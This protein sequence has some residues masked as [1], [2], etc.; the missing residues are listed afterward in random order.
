MSDQ[1]TVQ[2]EV[3]SVT[4]VDVGTVTVLLNDVA[5]VTVEVDVT[6]LTDA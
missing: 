2:R 3:V 6:E 1:V 4:A 5:Q